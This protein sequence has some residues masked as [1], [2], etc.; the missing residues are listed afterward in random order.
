MSINYLNRNN[1]KYIRFYVYK[2]L[3]Y[4]KNIYNLQIYVIFFGFCYFFKFLKFYFN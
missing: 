1:V 4:Y 2:I 3:I